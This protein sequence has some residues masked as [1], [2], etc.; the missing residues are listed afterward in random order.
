[1]VL[2]HSVHILC[3]GNSEHEPSYLPPI[4]YA[5]EQ[6]LRDDDVKEEKQSKWNSREVHKRSK[7]F[8]IGW[9]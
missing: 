2:K 1:M 8:V 6:A 4:E 9:S 5:D 3:H 7:S